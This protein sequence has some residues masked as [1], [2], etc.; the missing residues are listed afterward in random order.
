MNNDLNEIDI[1]DTKN[2]EKKE[3]KKSEEKSDIEEK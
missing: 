1:I 3:N 2:E